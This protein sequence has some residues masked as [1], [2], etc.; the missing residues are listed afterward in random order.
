MPYVRQRN[1][2]ARG[3]LQEELVELA[4]RA[5]AAHRARCAKRCARRSPSERPAARRSRRSPVPR[6]CST[7]R[8]SRESVDRLAAEIA[9]DHP[10]G[11]VLVGVLKGALDLP[12]RPRPR[13]AATSTC[14]VDFIAISRYA[15]DSGR[16]RILH[17]VDLD[18]AG[19]DVVLV[20]D[21]VDTG[22][23]LGYLVEHLAPQGPRSVEVCTLLDRPARRILPVAGPLRRPRD[24][25]RV[26]A[27]LRA[28][29]RR[30]VPQR[31]PG[32]RRRPRGSSARDPTPTSGALRGGAEAAGRP[33]ARVSAS[34]DRRRP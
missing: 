14:A 24:P 12:R 18:L 23:T 4:P 34:P 25:R 19:R 11:V 22:L 15:P 32:R 5:A 10:D 17:D 31:P 29:P 26:R 20:E 7:R 8:R 1:P 6:R 21:L 9:A 13:H 16:V 2:E 33:G 30:S 28:A 27:R 3:R